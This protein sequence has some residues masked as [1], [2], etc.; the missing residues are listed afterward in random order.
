MPKA[1]SGASALARYSIGSTAGELIPKL[2]CF[3]L[4]QLIELE[5]PTFLGADRHE[6]KEEHLGLHNNYRP[7][8]LSTRVGEVI[9][10][11]SIAW[12]S[13]T[14]PSCAEPSPV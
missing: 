8:T 12:A 2:T 13:N 11:A 3:G 6:H 9:M 5:V 14:P 10:E 1:D 7:R 4:Q